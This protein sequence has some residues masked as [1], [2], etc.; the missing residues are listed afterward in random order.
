MTICA[1]ARHTFRN[2]KLFDN[3]TTLLRYRA[4]KYN[5]FITPAG[6]DPLRGSL[7]FD[8]PIIIVPR[9][10]IR[11]V[12]PTAQLI[13]SAQPRTPSISSGSSG[14]QPERLHVLAHPEPK[15][16]VVRPTSIGVGDTFSWVTYL[17]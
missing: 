3:E 16:C 4:S 2:L 1:T 15:C 11:R 13:R 8:P 14:S 5:I 17:P 7:Q 9:L 10:D 6:L 12:N